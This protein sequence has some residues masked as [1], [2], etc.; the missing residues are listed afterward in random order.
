MEKRHGKHGKHG[1][2]SATNDQ[3]QPERIVAFFALNSHPPE[4]VI[5]DFKPFRSSKK[6]EIVNPAQCAAL[7][8]PYG[9]GEAP[10]KTRRARAEFSNERSNTAR[11]DRSFLRAQQLIRR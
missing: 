3:T 4:W 10:R 2:N 7:I 5:V 1:R 6:L 11:T 8:A 9:S